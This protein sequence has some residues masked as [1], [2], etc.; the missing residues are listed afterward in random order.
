MPRHVRVEFPGAICHVTIRGNAGREIFAD[1]HYREKIAHLREYPWS[2]YRGYVGL[3]RPLKFVTYVPILSQAGGKGHRQRKEYCGHVES[4]IIRPDDEFM[5][6]LKES[7]VAIGGD[8]FRAWVRDA[9]LELGAK[10]AS[11]EDVAFRRTV[12]EMEAEKVLEIVS[13][14]L[15]VKIEALRERRRNSTLRAIAARMLVKYGNMNHRQVAK[16]MGLGSGV[17]AS[18]QARKAALLCESD[19]KSRELIAAIE[20]DL[21]VEATPHV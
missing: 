4:G 14:H 10:A 2:S 15:G 13:R 1:D 6:I 8:D 9:C 3:E 17:S 11:P 16:A 21:D 18:L 19:R 5:E 12:P 20:G 7:P